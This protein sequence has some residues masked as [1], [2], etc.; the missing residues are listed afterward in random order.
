[1]W[2]DGITKSWSVPLQAVAGGPRATDRFAAVTAAFVSGLAG[3]SRAVE[4]VAFFLD[5]A[6]SRLEEAIE[7]NS[8]FTALWDDLLLVVAYA[9]EDGQK[10]TRAVPFLFLATCLGV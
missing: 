3:T 7:V 2:V 8:C 10:G 6:A 9:H 1:M 4:V 5:S